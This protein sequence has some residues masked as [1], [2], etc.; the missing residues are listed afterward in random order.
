M[1]KRRALSLVVAVAG[2]VGIGERLAGGSVIEGPKSYTEVFYV[3]VNRYD[4]DGTKHD[5]RLGDAA[6]FLTFAGLG[7]VALRDKKPKMRNEM[8]DTSDLGPAY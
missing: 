2:L 1:N 8:V 6:L 7:G 5:D 4:P 3:S